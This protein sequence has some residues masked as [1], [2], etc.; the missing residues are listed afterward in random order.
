MYGVQP[1]A[2]DMEFAHPISG[3]LGDELAHRLRVRPIEVECVSPLGVMLV[4]QIRSRELRRVVSTG[5][6][7]VVDTIENN[8]QAERVRLIDERAKVI[9]ASIKLSRREPV[10]AVVSPAELAGKSGDRHHLQ[11]CDAQIAKVRE[12]L[13]RRMP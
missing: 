5:T 12:P 9:W 3:I 8:T 4:R 11:C 10:D 13:H 2:V 6:K 1:E 7:V